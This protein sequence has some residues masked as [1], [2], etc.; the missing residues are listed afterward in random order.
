MDAIKCE[1]MILAAETGSLTAAGSHLGYTQSGI[2]R[3]LGSLEEEIGFPLFIRSKKGVTLT[4]NGKAILPMFREIVRAQQNAQQFSA[5]ICGITKGSLTVG[6][7]YS[8][9]AMWMPE[10][11]KEFHNRFPGVSIRIQEGSN[12]NIAKW[13]HEKSVDCCLC[14][15]PVSAEHDW[16]SIYQDELVAWIPM[17][18]PLAD[19]AA[20]PIE[21]LEKED[22]IHTTPGQ[23]TTQDRL[24]KKLH[25]HPRT[26]FTTRDGFT[27]YNMVGAGLGISFNQR[28][29]SKKWNLS[30]V[31]EKPFS[32]PQFEE[33]GI[34][35]PSLKESS[36]AAKKLIEF[37][38]QHIRSANTK[39]AE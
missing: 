35:V 11:L 16:I 19:A 26:I 31:I 30:N 36:P 8:I 7:Y 23:D 10:I 22:F 20:F 5:Q 12:Q 33:L 24:L 38:V 15:R 2:T 28:L 1:A 21:N 18:H 13:L 29:L 37:A 32:P 3:M 17:D 34:A 9:A 27:T 39:T 6:C 14:S 25:L 4:E